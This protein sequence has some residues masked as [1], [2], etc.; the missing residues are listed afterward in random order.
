MSKNIKESGLKVAFWFSAMVFMV[1]MT[2][3]ATGKVGQLGG[4]VASTTTAWM[5]MT[6]LVEI[7]RTPRG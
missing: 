3:L 6:N 7:L 4:V 1:L 5:F 2:V